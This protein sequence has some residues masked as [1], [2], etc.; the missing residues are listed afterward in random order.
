MMCR[1]RWPR[2][3]S[4]RRYCASL[5]VVEAIG[6]WGAG[7][8]MG[9]V[10]IA[11]SSASC[12]TFLLAQAHHDCVWSIPHCTM[13]LECHR[14]GSCSRPLGLGRALFCQVEVD[15]LFSVLAVTY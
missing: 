13:P 12:D 7:A 11:N 8:R 14:F 2:A 9:D 1:S 10:G 4:G 15:F 3:P 5:E 6:H